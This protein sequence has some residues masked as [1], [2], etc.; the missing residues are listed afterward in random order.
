[1]FRSAETGERLENGRHWFDDV[2]LE[3][4][5]TNFRWHDLRQ[6]LCD[7]VAHEGRGTGRYSGSSGAREVDD[8][9]AAG[10]SGG[11]NKLH[12][13]VSLLKRSDRRSDTRQSAL[14]ARVSEVVVQ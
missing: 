2:L 3:A 13:V 12:A 10:A 7:Q 11:P 4:G 8:D 9:E 5:I 14:P 1:V 6:Y